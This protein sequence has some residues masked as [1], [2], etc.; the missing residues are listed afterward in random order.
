V[1]CLLIHQALHTPTRKDRIVIGRL[2]AVVGALQKKSD[3]DNLFSIY[4]AILLLY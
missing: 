4:E 2:G 3:R 1:H